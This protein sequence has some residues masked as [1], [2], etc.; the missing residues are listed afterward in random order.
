MNLPHLLASQIARLAEAMTPLVFTDGKYIEEMGAKADCLYVIL[1]GEV[2]CHKSDGAEL[3]LTDGA[4]F[5]ES[6]L[7]RASQGQKRQANVVAVDTV[8]VA[9]LMADDCFEILGDLLVVL[10]RH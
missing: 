3:R 4:V 8:R 2:A 10:V 7:N 5:G 1:H 9:R 6:C